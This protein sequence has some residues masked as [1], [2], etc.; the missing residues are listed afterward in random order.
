MPPGGVHDCPN[1]WV[2]SQRLLCRF[3]QTVPH[4]WPVEGE[5]ALTQTS[6][7]LAGRHIQSTPTA[8]EDV[9]K[10]FPPASR[11][12][13]DMEVRRRG[14][15]CIRAPQSWQRSFA[16]PEA[17]GGCVLYVRNYMRRNV[18]I[19]FHSIAL[20]CAGLEYTTVWKDV[21]FD[22]AICAWRGLCWLTGD[23]RHV[24]KHDASNWEAVYHLPEQERVQLLINYLRSAIK[25]DLLTTGTYI[26]RFRRINDNA[27]VTKCLDHEKF[28][29]GPFHR[30][31]N[32][33]FSIFLCLS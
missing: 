12:L 21:V 1:R 25:A 22:L 8:V 18:I 16:A 31:T 5:A 11:I 30:K 6:V 15:I 28:H 24:C 29:H 20:M 14:C 3:W 13:A 9:L 33:K 26:T 32:M 10:L 17:S 7:L 4:C 27:D 19:T 2:F 23:E